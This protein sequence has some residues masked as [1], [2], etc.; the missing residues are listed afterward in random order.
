MTLQHVIYP[1]A[2]PVHRSGD[3]FPCRRPDR[4]NEATETLSFDTADPRCAIFDSYFNALNI[5]K[6]HATC[7]PKGLYLGL[8]GRGRVLVKVF[9]AIP[10]R[11]W[12]LLCDAP[13]TLSPAR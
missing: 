11:S 10:D 4:Y 5:G 9:H 12:E 6:W 3:V 8:K 7:Q 2:G 1:E 13:Y